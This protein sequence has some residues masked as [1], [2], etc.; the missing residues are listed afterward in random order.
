MCLGSTS[1][2]STAVALG[3]TADTASDFHQVRFFALQD[4][5]DLRA[6]QLTH[7][8]LYFRLPD[9]PPVEGRYKLL[10]T[11]QRG[12]VTYVINN[13]ASN[14]TVVDNGNGSYTYTP[15]GDFNGTDSF[16]YTAT[17]VNGDT[18]TQTVTVTVTV[19]VARAPKESS[20]V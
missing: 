3:S 9:D 20:M 6:Q 5:V 17:D 16:T 12:D 2:E 14:G 1:V 4:L 15:N 13:N 11:P 19:A 8:Y 7:G 10:I 18:E